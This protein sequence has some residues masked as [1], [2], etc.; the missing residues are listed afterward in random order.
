[1]AKVSLRGVRRRSVDFESLW[2]IT[3]A[4]LMVQL[5]AFFAVI[6]SFSN[7]DQSQLSA[8]VKALQKE[9]GVKV[10]S[11]ETEKGQ[12]LLP[13][14]TGLM[15]EKATDLEKLLNDL[16]SSD[17]PD[18]GTRMRIVSF[19]G[20]VLFPEN[21][22]AV[23]PVFQPLIT[24]ISKLGVEYPGFQLICEG[25][26]A[27]GERRG[28]ADAL[29]LSGMRAQTIVRLLVAQGIDAKTIAAE[30]HGDSTLDGNPDSPEGR[31]LQRRVRFRFQRLAE[32]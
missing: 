17:G 21:S 15:P 23:D 24:R 28:S 18:V 26:A 4:D 22:A 8:V 12:G 13:G 3:F 20:A 5:M 16:K 27:P 9:L 32:R 19:R 11:G 14:Q 7:Q 25:H 30:A 2:L 1:V 31:A 6:Y 29:E 10:A